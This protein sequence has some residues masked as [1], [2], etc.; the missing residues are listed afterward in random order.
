[1][2]KQESVFEFPCEFPI[3]VVGKAA[4][5]F[6]TTIMD[7]VRRHVPDLTEDSVR[8]TGSKKGKFVSLTITIVAT[9]REQLDSIYRD[10]SSCDSVLMAL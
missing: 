8:S 1:M 2:S 5:S 6:Q 7:I 10:L 4:P 3:K 9:G